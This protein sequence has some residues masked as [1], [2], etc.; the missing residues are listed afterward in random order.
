MTKRLRFVHS[1]NFKIVALLVCSLLFGIAL[2]FACRAGGEYYIRNYYMSATSSAVRRAEIYNAFRSYVLE[3]QLSSRDTQA[4]NRWNKAHTYSSVSVQYDSG[5]FSPYNNSAASNSQNTPPVGMGKYYLRF[6]D[7]V[8]PISIT[9]TSDEKQLL[10]CT[11]SSVVAGA[12]SVIFVVFFYVNHLTKRVTFLA[13]SAQKLGAG[14]LESVIPARGK[15]EIAVLASEMDSMRR[16]VTQLISSE[17]EAR[18]ANS[19]LI[20][21]MS[22]DLRTP[23][24]SMIG[25]LELLKGGEFDSEQQREKFT[26]SAYK[27]A[28]EL[29]ELTDEM[30]RYFLVFGG[31]EVEL[32]LEEYNATILLEQMLVE[33]VVELRDAGY[34]VHIARLASPCSI[35][36]DIL[37]L[38]RIF[39]NLFSNIR[40][41]ADPQRPIIIRIENPSSSVLSISFSNDIKKDISKTERNRI[42]LKTCSKIAEQMGGRFTHL[43][44]GSRFAAELSL[45]AYPPADE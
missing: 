43:S 34:N 28:M 27:K 18:Q 14:D 19:S 45:P 26:D 33:P 44:E 38:K 1:L 35:R 30:F 3:N 17:C 4:I 9:D 13:R 22:H 2:F 23:M 5:V 32:T 25:Y 24:T 8:Y 7:G 41:Y 42:G 21:S 29:K 10:V 40:K 39:D 12:L 15:D 6:T 20:T 31:Q 16:A 11:A 36:V 37:N